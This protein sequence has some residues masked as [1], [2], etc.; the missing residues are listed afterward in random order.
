[1]TKARALLALG[2][3]LT[4]LCSCAPIVWVRPNTSPAEFA[5]DDARCRLMAEDATP[6]PGHPII[7]TGKP[8]RDVGLNIL[9]DLAYG[10]DQ[11]AAFQ[12]K[13]DLCM[14]AEGYVAYPAGAPAPVLTAEPAPGAPVQLTPAAYTSVAS[15]PASPETATQ[16]AAPLPAP[17]TVAAPRQYGRIV[18]WPVVTSN[19]YYPHWVVPVAGE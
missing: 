6:N 19:G 3:G 17:S 12:H 7:Y 5:M 13:H 11:A 15:G 18:L 4:A 8:R 16:P 9:A 1:M 14:Q 2:L 10:I